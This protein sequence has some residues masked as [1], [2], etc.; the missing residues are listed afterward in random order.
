M[1]KLYPGITTIGITGTIGAGK[2]TVGK[3]LEDLGIPVIDSDQIVHNLLATDAEVQNLIVERFGN[4]VVLQNSASNT[5]S[6]DRKAL[7]Q[8]IF[9]DAQKRA[10][11]EA[12]LHPRVRTISRQKLDQLAQDSS[13]KLLA[14]LVPRLFEANLGDEYDHTWTVITEPA[15][16]KDRLKQRDKFSPAELEGRLAT[17]WSQEKKASLADE[18]IDNSGDLSQTKKQVLDLVDRLLQANP[19]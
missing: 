10:A 14:Y 4:S 17:Q 19:K 15:V 13:V 7:G 1:G 2:S 11:L 9:E 6:I 3:F 16:L 5:K 8:V 12:I 18:R